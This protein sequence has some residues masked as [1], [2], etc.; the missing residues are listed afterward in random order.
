MGQICRERRGGERMRE[1][2]VRK[3]WGGGGR[4]D[5]SGTRG[6]GERTS[7]N[8]SERTEDGGWWSL[9]VIMME[10]ATGNGGGYL[11]GRV[12]AGWEGG[13]SDLRLLQCCLRQAEANSTLDPRLFTNLSD[14]TPNT[15]FS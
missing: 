5:V 12:V 9:G 2:K 1:G 7:M 6:R 15:V 10:E 8:N 4:R 13:V 14:T 11:G 3:G